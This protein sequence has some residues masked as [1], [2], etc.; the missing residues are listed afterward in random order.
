M[1]QI[2]GKHAASNDSRRQGRKHS[3]PARYRWLAGPIVVLMASSVCALTAPAASAAPATIISLTFDDA[4]ADQVPAAAVIN[5]LGM[6]GTFFTPSGYLDQPNYMTTAQALA[7]QTA[8]NEIGGHTVTHPD[9]TQM[10]PQEA[11]RQI[12]NDRVNLANKGLTT[13]DF[14]YPFAASN[15]ATE[16]I[17]KSCGFNS[18]RGLGDLESKVPGSQ[19]FGFAESVP[20]SDPYLTRA[21]DEIDNSWTLLDMQNLVTKAEPGGG[22]V[23]LTFHHIG[24]GIDPGSGAADPLTVTPELFGEFAH[25]LAQQ[26]TSGAITVQTVHQVIGGNTKPLVN[27]PA[28]PAPRTSGNL[29]Q[30]PSLETAGPAGAAGLPKCWAAGSFG[31]NTPTFTRVSPGHGGTATAAQKLVMSGYSSGDAKLLQTQDLGECAPSASP[32]H[33]YQMKAWYTS[34]AATQFELYYRTGLGSWAYW[35]ASPYFETAAKWTQA[36]WTSPPVPAGATAIS[37]GLNLFANG[38]LTT[39]DYELYDTASIKMFSDVTPTT[40][41]HDEISWLSNNQISQGYAD[42]TY[43]PVTPI[44]RDAMAA[45]LYRLAGSPAVPANAPTFPDVRPDNEFYNEIRWL[46]AMKI[47]TGYDDGGFHP[48]ATVNR[49]AMAAFMY[50]F[51]GSPAVPAS[52]PTFPDVLPNNPFYKE[53]RWLADTGI[54]TGYPDGTFKPVQPINRDAMA[55]FMYRYNLNFPKG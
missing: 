25:W 45:F 43:R 33:T 22:W 19:G 55:A 39:D 30:N 44:N 11:A 2:L 17:V 51:R 31:V 18:A 46:A 40:Q 1:K 21:P 41:F 48:L 49:D 47:T 50:R 24:T 23:Q 32:G 28:A 53:I 34:T 3:G 6:H 14:A 27:G 36:T 7:L 15:A 8:G 26:Q 35:T 5:G 12:C 38:V 16:S 20:P 4:N 10:G 54:T 9:L 29:I 42:G 37:V 52:A 13:T